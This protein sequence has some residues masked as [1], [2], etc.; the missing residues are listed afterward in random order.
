MTRI[1]RF[2][3]AAP[4]Q[5]APEG[6]VALPDA[7]ARHAIRVLRL[8]PGAKLVLFDGQGG[9]YPARIE[10]ITDGRNGKVIARLGEW[11]EIERE[12]P[13]A[14][15]LAQ[16]LQAGEKMDYTLQKATELGVA[17]FLPL[18]GRR[19]TTRLSDERAQKRATHWR[20]IAIAACE[21]CGRNRLP[22]IAPLRDLV[23][24]LTH[25]APHLSGMKII[26]SPQGI[27]HLA[28]AEFSL[29]DHAGITLLI[30]AEGG[31]SPEEN[32]LAQEAGFRPCHLGSRILRTET[33]SIA[34]LAILGAR[35]AETVNN[36][37][38]EWHAWT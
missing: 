27:Q 13:V 18:M 1:P 9:E 29:S 6:C 7:V 25:T 36:P 2:F 38:E 33:A 31:F 8:A 19:S 16:T 28:G 17:A 35:A 15:T 22:E 20:G 21:Q 26:L 11:Q 23:D 34:A 10:R 24:W 12:L 4:L 37:G 14:I 30:G 5:E 32:R 3:Y